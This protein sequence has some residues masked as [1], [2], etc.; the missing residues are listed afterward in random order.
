MTPTISQLIPPALDGLS[1]REINIMSRLLGRL[2]E[3]QKELPKPATAK[4]EA[5]RRRRENE[6]RRLSMT[7]DAD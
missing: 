6:R 1:R 3:L 2:S 7:S 5:Q 4:G